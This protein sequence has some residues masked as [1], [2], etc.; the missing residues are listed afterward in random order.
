[1]LSLIYLKDHYRENQ[2]VVIVVVVIVR[3]GT[4]PLLSSF[5]FFVWLVGFTV[6][7][8]FRAI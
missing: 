8:P 4:T 6:H 3:C 5:V 1:M 7:K 2:T